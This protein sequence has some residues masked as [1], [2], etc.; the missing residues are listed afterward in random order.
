MIED[1][2]KMPLEELEKR[3]L[4]SLAKQ[5]KTPEKLI[6]PRDI[7]GFKKELMIYHL[8]IEELITCSKEGLTNYLTN[9]EKA[10][11]EIF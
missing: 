11:K 3:Y 10:R 6:I 9:L 7:F 4:V 5:G 2:N 8:L 1:Y